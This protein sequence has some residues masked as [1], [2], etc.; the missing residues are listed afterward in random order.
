MKLTVENNHHAEKLAQALFI[1]HDFPYFGSVQVEARIRGLQVNLMCF[2]SAGKGSIH[3]LIVPHWKRR[4]TLYTA[5]MIKDFFIVGTLNVTPDSFHDGGRFLSVQ[6]AVER[7]GE[8]LLDGADII[9]I[10]GESTGPTSQEVSLDE[11]LSRVI[12]VVRGIKEAFPDAK[13][14]VDTWKAL[15]AIEALK[16]NVMMI[17]DVTAG[18]GSDGEMFDVLKDS[19]AQL[20]LMYA[21]DSSARTT[22]QD[23]HY[24]D[25]VLTVREFLS[26][27]KGA[28]IAAGIDPA[29]IILDP[30]LGHFLSSDA[31]YS[32]QVLARLKEFL[33]LDSPLFVS[34]SRKSFLAGPEK[35][36]TAERLPGTIAASVVALQNGA[37]YIRTHDV[38]EV[39]R[40][41]EIAE[42][43]RI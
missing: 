7:A 18:R 36:P 27:R 38:L 21:K 25:V 26:A 24:N 15:V 42:L 39:R 19:S 22:I 43:F 41:C 2:R 11:E 29:K 1:R 35:L 3:K 5:D 6:A 12:P 28:A 32:F 16:E 31:K 33:S 20:V 8:M 30:G 14:S 10:G 40:A 23:E 17:N 4:P 37:T 9:E 34:P 13:I